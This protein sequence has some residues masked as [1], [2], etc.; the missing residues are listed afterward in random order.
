MTNTSS[1]NRSPN[2][3]AASH[4]GQPGGTS[5]PLELKLLKGLS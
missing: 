3:N 1:T 4:C 5:P 2:S